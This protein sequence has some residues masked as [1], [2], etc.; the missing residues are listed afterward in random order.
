[1]ATH[2]ASEFARLFS[3]T[4]CTIEGYD[5]NK[6]HY[7]DPSSECYS[8][9]T[10]L[11]SSLTSEAYNKFGFT[12]EYYVKQISTKRDKIYGEDALENIVRRFKLSVYTDNVPHMEKHYMIQGMTYTDIVHLQCSIQHFKEA[13]VRTFITNEIAYEEYYPKIGDLM[14]FPWNKTFYEIINVKTFSDGSSFL[15][16]PITFEFIVKVWKPSHEDVNLMHQTKDG[17]EMQEINTIAS[18]GEVFDIDLNG[19]QKKYVADHVDEE[20]KVPFSTSGD[21]LAI[22]NSLNGLDKGLS[23][24]K[25]INDIIYRNN[26]LDDAIFDPFEN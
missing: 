18:L 5:W 3:T 20:K 14:Y 10:A 6:P 11:M 15:T 7:F 1:M 12:V 19:E 17:D 25:S 26:D 8:A 4:G 2:F 13:S 16:T 22:N 9:E 23:K 21:I 24:E